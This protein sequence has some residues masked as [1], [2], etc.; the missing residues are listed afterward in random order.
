MLLN[1]VFISVIV[2]TIA[3]YKY[4]YRQRNELSDVNE[5]VII[6]EYTERQLVQEYGT[7]D[8]MTYRMNN[9]LSINDFHNQDN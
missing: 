1:L 5:R 6:A 8:V 4:K 2:Y 3:S 9:D 7:N